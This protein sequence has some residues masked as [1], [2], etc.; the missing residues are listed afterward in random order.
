MNDCGTNN[1]FK[2]VTIYRSLWL[3]IF[4]ITKE[5]VDKFYYLT[6]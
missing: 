1:L 2:L 5:K 3:Q 6:N 4:K